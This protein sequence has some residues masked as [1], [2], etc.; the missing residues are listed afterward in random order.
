MV[1]KN[2][3]ASYEEFTEFWGVGTVKGFK[4]LDFGGPRVELSDAMAQ[5]VECIS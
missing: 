3:T 4:F 5:V 1:Q 2:E